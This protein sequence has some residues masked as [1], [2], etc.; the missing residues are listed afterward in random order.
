MSRYRNHGPSTSRDAALSLTA[1]RLA[2]ACQ[3]VLD[4]IKA[5]GAQGATTDDVCVALDKLELKSSVSRRITDLAEMGL[6]ECVGKRPG[7]AGRN[8]QVW[9]AATSDP[10]QLA[11]VS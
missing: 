4:T 2:S 1:Q 8:Q 7:R 5:S 3:E 10:V 6:V 11:L 9:I